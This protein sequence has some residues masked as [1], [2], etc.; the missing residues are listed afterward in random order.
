M[1][2]AEE[3]AAAA[4]LREPLREPRGGCGPTAAR[5][6]GAA[7]PGECPLRHSPRGAVRGCPAVPCPALPS[8]ALRAA[9]PSLA[10]PGAAGPLLPRSL[11]AP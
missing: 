3:A 4:V 11:R 2:I 8:P 10:W 7:L 9:E 1:E 5:G 6:S